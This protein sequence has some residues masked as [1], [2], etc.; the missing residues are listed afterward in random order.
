MKNILKRLFSR[1]RIVQINQG[2]YISE[3]RTIC[4]WKGIDT[5]GMDSETGNMKLWSMAEFK[6]KY[7]QTETLEA[8]KTVMNK[9]KEKTRSFRR[10]V[11]VIGYM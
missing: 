4:G 3:T 7:C 2:N 1:Y 6:D 9:Y 5:D 8:A 10:K 11:K